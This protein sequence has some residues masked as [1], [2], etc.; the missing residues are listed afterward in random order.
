MSEKH[1]AES[2]KNAGIDPELS[3]E[4]TEFLF[5]AGLIGNYDSNTGYVQFYHRRDTYKFKKGGPWM[6][7]KGL[8]YAFNIPYAGTG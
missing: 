6:L 8:M 5:L 4:L 1:F 7:H 3:S 2:L